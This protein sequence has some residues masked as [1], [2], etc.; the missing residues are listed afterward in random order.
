MNL[1]R[2][3]KWIDKTGNP[4]SIQRVVISSA[5]PSSMPA[6]SSSIASK[7]LAI[8]KPQ[9]SSTPSSVPHH[10]CSQH[11]R[12]EEIIQI[13]QKYQL[14]QEDQGSYQWSLGCQLRVEH[15]HPS[16]LLALLVL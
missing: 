11:A 15:T 13:V 8:R 2:T 14:S 1:D 6:G 4:Y 16:L 7:L 5:R 3:V 10:P 9:R 12:R